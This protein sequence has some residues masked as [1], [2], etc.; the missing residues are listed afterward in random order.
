MNYNDASFLVLFA[1]SD[2]TKHIRIPTL[3]K[4]VTVLMLDLERK[5]TMLPEERQNNLLLIVELRNSQFLTRVCRWL[6]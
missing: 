6:K 4:G 3:Y 5:L 1:V 2:E